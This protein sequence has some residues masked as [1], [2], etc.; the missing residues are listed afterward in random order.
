[1][2]RGAWDVTRRDPKSHTTYPSHFFLR[3]TR[4]PWVEHMEIHQP[5]IEFSCHSLTEWRGGPLLYRA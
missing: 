3:P 5:P 1:M 4:L 2:E